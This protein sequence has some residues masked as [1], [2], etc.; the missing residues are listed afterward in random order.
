MTKMYDI[1]VRAFALIALAICQLP[2]SHA[3]VKSTPATVT[4]TDLA[5]INAGMVDSSV[6]VEATVKSIAMPKE[7]SK[8]PVRVLLSDSTGTMTLVM[9][10]DIFDV[11]KAKSPIDSGALIHV[12]A[13]VSN[14]KDKLQ[15]QIRSP[16]EIRVISKSESEAPKEAPA[17]PTPPATATEGLTPVGSITSEMIGREVTVKASIS[18]VREPRE[19]S[20]APC[21]VTL[22]QDSTSIPLVFWSDIEQQI[23]P[24]LKVGNVV[25]VK[26]Q[27]G[28][29]KGN[30]QIKLRNAADF[31]VESAPTAPAE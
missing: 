7:G 14:Y 3:A 8:S 19:G 6:E 4:K 28:D 25:Q 24:G 23:K 27:V 30:L 29:H 10:P 12:S 16:A 15:L 31:H 22:S 20:K 9:W 26:A 21:I 17:S 2:A 18:D 11:L 1:R 5:S 13:H